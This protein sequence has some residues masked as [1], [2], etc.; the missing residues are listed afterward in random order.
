[1]R[2]RKL[3]SKPYSRFEKNITELLSVIDWAKN[4]AKAVLSKFDVR[5]DFGLS[6]VIETVE[7]ATENYREIAIRADEKY[8][9]LHAYGADAN[10]KN[11]QKE[12]GKF[13]VKPSGNWFNEQ[14][15]VMIR[16][17]NGG[18]WTATVRDIRA[19]ILL[20]HALKYGTN[21]TQDLAQH[22]NSRTT[23]GYLATPEMKLKHEEKI[24]AF[25]EWLQVLVTINIDDIPNKLGLAEDAYDEIKERIVNSRF[26][27]SVCSDPMG[28]HQPG[29]VVGK[30]CTQIMMCMTCEKRSNLFVAS[31]E[32]VA[33]L[34]HWRDALKNA[35][36]NGKISENNLNWTLWGVF[37]DT[38][39]D[40][41][42][43]SL[44]HK[45]LLR[46][47]RNR[48]AEDENPYNRIFARSA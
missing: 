37:I 14:S 36:E 26:G 41:L 38:M 19:S 20:A 31:E 27:G 2:E 12:E 30:P 39:H 15:K 23:V 44:K 22:S 3:S 28:G 40:R 7:K 1:M 4:R 29:S 45:G 21:S 16:E 47:V 35:F 5:S 43:R 10:A 32:N 6:Y 42:E 24:R 18:K 46:D 48:I 13:L 17:I 8:L 33:H 34:L 11:R 9:F 25:Q